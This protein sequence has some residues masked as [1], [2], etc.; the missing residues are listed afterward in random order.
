MK[1]AAVLIIV[2]VAF[3]AVVAPPAS[4]QGA[5]EEDI[6]V[7]V[8]FESQGVADGERVEI[9]PTQEIKVVAT[10]RS[11]NEL[12]TLEGQVRNTT[13]MQGI[14]GTSHN[15][16]HAISTRPGPNFYTVE[17]VD[18]EGNAATSTVN[19]YRIPSNTVQVKRV[20]E[21]LEQ[22]KNSIASEIDSLKERKEELQEEN[23]D[24]RQRR[25]EAEDELLALEPSSS[26]PDDD[27]DN[28]G[29]GGG[30]PQPG[31]VT[32]GESLPGFTAVA[33]LVAVL[34]AAVGANRRR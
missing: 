22:R 20:I 24:L 6:S 18:M 33:A 14:N 11:E 21:R 23:E 8:S 19:F 17:V 5:Q 26:G 2:A 28:D 1:R 25:Q 10:A 34:L 29:E 12:N 7:S 30:E 9:L 4:A 27:G 3:V 32:G 31:G 13:V 15:V 16:S